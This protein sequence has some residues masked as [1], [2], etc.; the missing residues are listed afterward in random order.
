MTQLQNALA[1]QK[2][3]QSRTSLDDG[4]YVARLTRL[5]GLIRQ[6][7]HGFRKDWKEVPSWLQPYVNRD[8]LSVGK[9][10]MILVGR[11]FMSR[12][13]VE[14]VFKK[15]FH[16]GLEPSLS[17]ALQTIQTN[18]RYNA[19][20]LVTDEEEAALTDKIL[21]WRM[22]TMEGLAPAL[23]NAEASS[24]RQ[25]FIEMLNAKLVK[26]LLEHM[27][28]PPDG[29]EGGVNMIIELV[30]AIL[31]HLPE[32]SRDVQIDYF[33]AGTLISGEI[34]NVETG[35]PPLTDPI[36]DMPAFDNRSVEIN[37]S[38]AASVSDATT[39]DTE[40][41]SQQESSRKGFLGSIIGSKKQSIPN[42]SGDAN[43]A[44]N[45]DAS[46]NDLVQPPG[47]SAGESSGGRVRFAVA[48]SLQIRGRKNILHKALVFRL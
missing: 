6:L 5:D 38:D 37:I 23:A 40:A 41:G 28:G 35:I 16:P 33:A 4:E 47:S 26:A 7:A 42:N 2:L 19:P 44:G 48:P 22:T 9:Q 15:Y 46:P 24:R 3:S 18:L 36:T 31:T 12:W 25:S 11:A 1:H 43:K 39:Q 14:E 32:E 8:A 34:M 21:M 17:A 30:V 10:E 27:K 13:I 45:A 29:L 20:S